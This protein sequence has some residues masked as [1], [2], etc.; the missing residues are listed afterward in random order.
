MSFTKFVN[1]FGRQKGGRCDISP[2]IQDWLDYIDMARAVGVDLSR[3]GRKFPADAKAA[4]DA[5]LP[6]FLLV[7]HAAEEA[8]WDAKIGSVYAGL[9]FLRYQDGEYLAVLPEH[10]SDLISEGTSLGHCV[11]GKSY[12]KNHMGGASL[13][14]FI[15]RA[16]AEKVPFVTMELRMADFRIWQIH[17]AGNSN[18]PE[19]VRAF[20]NKFVRELKA[21]MTAGKERAA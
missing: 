13:I 18:P 10:R 3:K 2:I 14:V 12:A 4:H 20:A 7:K 9:P 11:G 21:A 19:D 6:D 17:G 15:R 8:E 5:I 16:S 1:Y